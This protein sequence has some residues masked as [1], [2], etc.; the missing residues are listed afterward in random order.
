MYRFERPQAGRYREHYQ[1]GAEAIGSAE[2]ALDAEMIM[3]LSDLYTALAVPDVTLRL[4][5]MGCP[6]CRPP[7]TEQLQSY[8]GGVMDDLCDDCRERA[9]LNPLRVFDCK[10]EACLRL[11][12]DAPKLVDNLCGQCRENFQQVQDFLTLLGRSY[13]VD[14]TLVRGFDYYTGTTFEF[15]CERLG[16]QKGIGGGGRYDRLVAEIGGPDLPAVGF[17]TGLE[18]IILA[19]KSAG[20]Q[21]AGRRIDVFFAV[22]DPGAWPLAV[23]AIH[24]LRRKGISAD[25]DYAGRKM[26]GQMKQADR[27]DASATV[28]IG[29]DELAAG[30]ATVK[31]MKTGGQEKVALED[32]LVYL[33]ERLAGG[34]NRPGL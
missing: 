33:T 12:A 13:Q 4:G 15:E 6:G 2:P 22:L 8:L 26:K 5:S 34:S 10:N 25:T 7:Y 24:D 27:L 16:A 21:A 14:G 30:E 11:L 1:L 17:G 23:E 18:R 32:L 29:G 3:M 20:A 9:G 19:M 31:D 28:I